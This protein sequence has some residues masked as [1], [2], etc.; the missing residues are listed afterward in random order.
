MKVDKS[1]VGKKV[2]ALDEDAFAHHTGEIGTVVGY[3][4]SSYSMH[5]RVRWDYDGRVVSMWANDDSIELVEDDSTLM[6]YDEIWEMLKPKMEKNEL[7]SHCY[8]ICS[9]V[10]CLYNPKDFQKAVAL[11]YKMG[12]ERAVKGRPFKYGEKKV[13]KVEGHWEKVDPENLPK[14]ETR[15]RYARE[16]GKEHHIHPS[17][18]D[19]GTVEWHGGCG[20]GFRRDDD[21][22]IC[23]M[24][25]PSCLDYWVEG[26][27]VD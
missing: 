11:A 2:R 25:N 18:G 19:E 3:D 23:V 5:C 15:V 1:W 26:D 17:I 9:G 6:P 24:G 7:V 20:I 16:D 27:D 4:D 13:K 8:G 10:A 22:W 21:S 12:Y 14:N